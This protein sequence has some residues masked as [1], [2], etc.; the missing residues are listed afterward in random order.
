MH[1]Y[2][3]PVRPSVRATVHRLPSPPCF[4]HH[5][6]PNNRQ[7]S[8][9]TAPNH[10]R[11]RADSIQ[12]RAS[13]TCASCRI[14]RVGKQSDRKS[15]ALFANSYVVVRVKLRPRSSNNQQLSVGVPCFWLKR[16]WLTYEYSSAYVAGN[17]NCYLLHVLA[18]SGENKEK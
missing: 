15:A 2:R 8:P 10:P 9:P 5:S 4:Y 14:N 13:Y 11:D 17:R 18:R 6:W 16:C 3:Y 7:L 1:P 12:G